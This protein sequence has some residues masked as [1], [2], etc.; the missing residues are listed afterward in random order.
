[1]LDAGRHLYI[2]EF[3]LNKSAREAAKQIDDR[4]YAQKYIV[5]SRENGITI[6]K[7]GINFSTD[8]ELRNINDRKETTV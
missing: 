1:M 3:K 4:A 2:M 7:L 6:H 8:H 5:K